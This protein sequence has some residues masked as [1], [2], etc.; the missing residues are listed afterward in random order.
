MNNLSNS[1]SPDRASSVVYIL[2][3]LWL[4]T[5]MCIF[6]CATIF[7]AKLPKLS[8]LEKMEAGI[9]ERGGRKDME[10]S[11]RLLVG[12]GEDLE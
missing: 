7:F 6:G 12:V 2:L 9:L 4:S 10:I 5:E 3:V 1:N 8:A 11:S